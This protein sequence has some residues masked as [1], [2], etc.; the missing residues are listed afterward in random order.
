MASSGGWWGPSS[1]SPGALAWPRG[2]QRQRPGDGRPAESRGFGY[3]DGLLQRLLRP[4]LS[5]LL[6]ESPPTPAALS[7]PLGAAN[8]LG[9]PTVSFQHLGHPDSGPP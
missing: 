2:W 4:L 6:G 3:R 7:E 1:F 8:I 9:N 5:A